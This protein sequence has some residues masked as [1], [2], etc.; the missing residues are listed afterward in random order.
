[1]QDANGAPVSGAK[2]YVYQAGTTTLATTYSDAALTTPNTNPIIADTAGRFVAYLAS[3]QSYKFTIQTAAGVAIRTVDNVQAI[4]AASG[5]LDVTGVAGEALLAGDVVYLSDGSGGLVAGKW[6]KADADN[7]YSSTLPTVGIVPAAMAS[8]ASGTVRLAGRVTALS[9]LVV[10]STYY[11]SATAGTITTSA[12]TNARL[13]GSADSATSL[14]L[15]IN[16]A[17]ASVPITA[18]TGTWTAVSFSAGD[19]TGSGSMT[20][21]VEAGDVTAFRYLKIGKTLWVSFYIVTT[22][23]AGT[24]S[25]AL[26]I[27]IPGSY[28]AATAMLVPVLLTDNGTRATGYASVVADATVITVSRTDQAN[29]GASTNQTNVYGQIAFEIK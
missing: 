17:A 22:T 2:V 12:P 25:T 14:V 5:N 21:T 20:W 9:S 27:K 16:T 7:T 24:P 3:G 18:L 4:P 29:Y 1:V 19:F 23:I 10:G 28:A 8:G 13:L 26:Q 6:Y 11:I 15:Q